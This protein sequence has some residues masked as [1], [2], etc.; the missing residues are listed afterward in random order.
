MTNDQAIAAAEKVISALCGRAGFDDWWADVHTE[1]QLDIIAEIA[2]TIQAD[3]L[4]ARPEG[5]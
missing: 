3:T 5:A 4:E 1:D 2:T